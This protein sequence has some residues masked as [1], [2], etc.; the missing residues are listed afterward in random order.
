MFLEDDW[1]ICPHGLHAA[2]HAIDKAYRYD[3]RWLAL[4]VSYGFNGIVV[5]TADVPNLRDST[6]DTNVRMFSIKVRTNTQH[7]PKVNTAV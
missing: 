1:L 2:L 6:K 7:G 5:P 3:P 4:R